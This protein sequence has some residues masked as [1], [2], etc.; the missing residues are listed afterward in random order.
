MADDPQTGVV[1]VALPRSDDPVQDIGPQQKHATLLYFGDVD[2][3]S[4]PNTYMN[5]D[6]GFRRLLEQCVAIV[7]DEFAPFTANVAG[8]ESLGDG[9]AQVWMLDTNVPGAIRD[10]VLDV[11]SE[12][13]SALN[14][15]EQ[16]PTYTP[17]VTIG[18]E[19]GSDLTQG[20]SYAPLADGDL[21]AA[22]EISQI[23]FD[24]L[25]VWWAGEQTEFPLAGIAESERPSRPGGSMSNQILERGRLLDADTS[26]AGKI[27]RPIQIITPGWGSSGY[28]SSD[29]LER[30]AK[31]RVIPK[32]THMYLNHA[33]ESERSDRPEREVEK[34]AAVLVE[35][36]RWDGTRL[37]ADAD[38]MGPHAELVE[39]VAPYIGVSISGSATDITIGEAEGRRGPIIE[40]LAVVDSVDFV[41][42]AGRGGMVLLESARPSVVNAL[43]IEHGISESTA[44]ETRE[45][46]FNALREK[47]PGEKVWTWVRDFDESTVWYEHETPEDCGTYSLGYSISDDGV[48]TFSGDPV[49]VR[50]ETNYVPVPPG[51]NTK[52]EEAEAMAEDLNEGAAEP[53]SPAASAPGTEPVAESTPTPSPT[54]ENDMTDTN[55]GAGGTA[56]AA[57][58]AAPAVPRNPR[59]VMEAQM[60]EQGRQIALLRAGQKAHGIVTEVL[61]AGWIG[62]AQSVRLTNELIA[63]S[64]LPLTEHGELDEAALRARALAR[65]DEAETEAAEILASAGVGSV[66]GLGSTTRATE[67]A[68]KQYDDTLAE[69][70]KELGMSESAVETAVKGR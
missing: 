12:L 61:A 15:V 65:L 36:A 35:D 45:L 48:V 16:Y 55:P 28:Y 22:A 2:G 64:T 37:I 9:G 10:D 42:H 54:K 53:G 6:A 47:F 4:N 14:S 41:T 68:L 29:V 11:D 67:V 24:R 60:R 66:K 18:Y 62:E 17:H 50:A 26:K 23:T 19:P 8:V 58:E 20:D 32:G 39:A 21:T 56:P 40:D 63:E 49:E 51:G 46:L 52:T 1:V 44:N 33:S 27:R 30:A 31:N 70:F 57:Q 13:A 3:G 59:E 69:S 7:A 5:A 38:L 25:A 34:I 43:A